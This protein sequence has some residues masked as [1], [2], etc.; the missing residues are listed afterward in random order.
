M[1]RPRHARSKH[2]RRRVF[3]A[4]TIAGG[5]LLALAPAALAGASKYGWG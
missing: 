2:W 4:A 5:T 3:V 1:Y